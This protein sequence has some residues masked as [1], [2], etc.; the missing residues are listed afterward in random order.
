MNFGGEVGVLLGICL[1]T[2]ALCFSWG[3]IAYQTLKPAPT[4]PYVHPNSEQKGEGKKG[5]RE[6]KRE[7]IQR[8][9]SAERQR[10]VEG[11]KGQAAS[12][13][14]CLQPVGMSSGL[15]LGRFSSSMST[16]GG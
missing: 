12:A 2:I 5:I 9:V 6:E 13:Q 10:P 3:H 4:H 1:V 11:R 7:G 16:C 15:C 8:G 14:V